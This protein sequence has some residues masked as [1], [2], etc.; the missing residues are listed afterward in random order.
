MSNLQYTFV[1][2]LSPLAAFGA[3]QPNPFAA[4]SAPAFGQSSATGGGLFGARPFGASASPFGGQQQPGGGLFGGGT[5]GGALGATQ[6]AFGAT[7]AFGQSTTTPAFGGTATFGECSV[8]LG[9]SNWALLQRR[10][11]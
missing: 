4:S 2:V 11:M 3:A 9:L 1:D 7:P 5:G 8:L 10:G 6:P